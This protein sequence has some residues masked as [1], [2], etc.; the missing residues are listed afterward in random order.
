MAPHSSPPRLP[1]R[2]NIYDDDEFDQLAISTSK[3]H[4][5]RRN[6]DHTAD[7]VLQDKSTAASKAA[8]LSALA[9]CMQNNFPLFSLLT[10]CPSG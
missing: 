1:T 6:P 5:G 8:I 3:L 9:A 10:P 4:F 7:D 2:R